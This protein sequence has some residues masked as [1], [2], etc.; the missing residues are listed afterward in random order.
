M[1]F[2]Y[3]SYKKDVLKQLQETKEKVLLEVA[4]IVEG[5][6]VYLVPVDTGNL[7]KTI[8]FDVDVKKGI[9]RVG[10]LKGK[11]GSEYAVFVERGTRYQKAQPFIKKAFQDSEKEI[12]KIVKE[13]FK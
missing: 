4:T 9:A 13:Y 11:E 1:G 5:R 8:D 10:V 7:R 12:Q 2:K 3:K 6:A